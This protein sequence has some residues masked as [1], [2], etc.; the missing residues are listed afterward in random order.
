V[1]DG[2]TR[3]N[4]A[5]RGGERQARTRAS[6][7]VEQLGL[8]V[9]GKRGNQSFRNWRSGFDSGYGT[10]HRLVEDCLRREPWARPFRPP[11]ANPKLFRQF[12]QEF[13]VEVK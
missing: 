3:L 5:L 8:D 2:N 9:S 1:P 6:Q 13:T 7:L 11:L 10:H 4:L 12:F